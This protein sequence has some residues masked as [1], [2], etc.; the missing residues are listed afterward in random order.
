M[1]LWSL[2]ILLLALSAHVIYKGINE[3]KRSSQYQELS[4]TPSGASTVQVRDLDGEIDR[5]RVAY[6]RNRLIFVCIIFAVIVILNL[7][8]CSNGRMFYYGIN[9]MIVLWVFLSSIFS[10]LFLHS[11]WVKRQRI[12]IPRPVAVVSVGSIVERNV[13]IAPSWAPLPSSESEKNGVNPGNN[14]AKALK[15]NGDGDSTQNTSTRGADSEH[16]EE[17]GSVEEG[18]TCICTELAPHTPLLGSVPGVSWSVNNVIFCPLI[19]SFAGDYP[20]TSSYDTISTLF[21]FKLHFFLNICRNFCG[22]AWYWWWIY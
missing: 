2:E 14:T 5:A 3:W 1:L 20:T 11:S 12:G 4:G 13:P 16:K 19:S 9:G 18:G 8:K 21:Y 22:D 6:I 15:K 7:V 17:H 10:G